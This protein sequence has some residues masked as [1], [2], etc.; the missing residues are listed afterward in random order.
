MGNAM[1]GGRRRKGRT[2]VMKIDGETMKLATPITASEVLSQH[3]DH[4]LFESQSLRNLGL[5]ATPLEPHHQLHPKALYFLL[6]LPPLPAHAPPLRRVQSGLHASATDRLEWLMLSRRSISDL[7]VARPPEP[8]AAPLQVKFRL[9]TAEM[10]RLLNECEDK[11][12]VAQRILNLYGRDT[13]RFRGGQ[14]QLRSTAQAST[15][16]A[17]EKRVSFVQMKDSPTQ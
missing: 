14:G 7:H 4:R 1:G 12:E 2:K 3:P 5:R 8:S 17:R 10:D 6:Q 9:P 16:K 15:C 11:A 13:D